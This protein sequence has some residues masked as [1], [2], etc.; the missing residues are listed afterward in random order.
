MIHQSQLKL[1]VAAI[2]GFGAL[3]GVAGFLLYDE[4][5]KRKK[6]RC[7]PVKNE[8]STLL[9]TSAFQQG[10]RSRTTSSS[11]LFFSDNE[12]LYTQAGSEF[13]DEEYYSLSEAE[14]R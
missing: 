9:K 6:S 14:E 8:D 12:S 1:I 10:T 7:V 3:V 13:S 4:F 2:F 11:T 5:Q